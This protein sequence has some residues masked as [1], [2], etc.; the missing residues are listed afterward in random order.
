MFRFAPQ[1]IVFWPVELPQRTEEGELVTGKAY[2]GYELLARDEL[3]E[4]TRNRLE[5]LDEGI[6]APARIERSDKL[7][8]QDGALLRAR[9]KDWRGIE[10]DA[11]DA[12][13]FKKATLE[14]LLRDPLLYKALLDGLLDA[15]AG[16]RSK[17]SL[18]GP[19]G[20]PAPA[21]STTA[22]GSGTARNDGAES[23]ATTAGKPAAA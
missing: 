7:D 15:S 4:R 13:P 10:N 16:A 18:P 20:A 12:V 22:A 21:Q 9:I 14:S 17:N 5:L 8:A 1:R 23:P 19:G 11:G 6:P 2:I 3:R